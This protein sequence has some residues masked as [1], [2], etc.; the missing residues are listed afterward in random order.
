[1]LRRI[2]LVCVTLLFVTTCL[3]SQDNFPRQSQGCSSP[4]LNA[5][6][7]PTDPVYAG[8]V[9]LTH[10]LEDH[11]N[12]VRCVL[13]SKMANVFDGQLGAALY[14][15]SRGDFE[16][17]F[18]PKPQTFASIRLIES[19]KNS[20]Y[21]RYLYSF[22]GTPRSPLTMDCARRTFF[23]RSANRLFVTE[24]KQLAASLGEILNPN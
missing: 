12:V 6:L 21:V 17:L 22:Q 2:L 19:H 24:D 5:L 10:E 16:A 13:Q 20:R 23:A 18:L 7:R 8:T 4:D 1:M 3:W 14:R 9:E 15:T 11:G